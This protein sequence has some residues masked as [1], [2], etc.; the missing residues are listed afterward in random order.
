[1][2]EGGSVELNPSPDLIHDQK[3]VFGSWVTSLGHV[4]DLVE[5]MPRWNMHPDVTCTH[6]FPLEKAGE[7]Y[8]TMDDGK[9]GKVAIV[10]DE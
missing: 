2:G 8:R 7:A 6:R 10:F 3:T 4:E 5:R 1:V 9:S